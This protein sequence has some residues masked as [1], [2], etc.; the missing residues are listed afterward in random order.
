MKLKVERRLA[1]LAGLLLLGLAMF[2]TGAQAA[3][4]ASVGRDGSGANAAFVS[5]H[6]QA[7]G[8]VAAA[9]RAHHRGVV[10]TLTAGTGLAVA[11]GR[12]PLDLRHFTLP[13]GTQPASSGTQPASS[14]T[15]SRTGWMAA[16]SA[17]SVLLVGFA[18]WALVRR[19]RQ[20]GDLASAS[21]CAQHPEDQMCTAA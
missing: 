10:G 2:A 9:R 4:A 17:V 21:Y 8:V 5:R 12:V 11:Q 1:S 14:G 16:G 18:A 15:A 3:Q 19:R 7:Q 13:S 20:L 6:T